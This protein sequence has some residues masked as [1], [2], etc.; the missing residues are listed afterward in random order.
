MYAYT[1]HT[2]HEQDVVFHDLLRL[3]L[4]LFGELSHGANWSVINHITFKKALNVT[5]DSEQAV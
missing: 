3:H 4:Q 2:M 5:A 1:H